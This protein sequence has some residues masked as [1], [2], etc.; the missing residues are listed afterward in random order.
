M[1]WV[2]T[3]AVSSV[4]PSTANS[5]LGMS[6]TPTTGAVVVGLNI[7]GLA[8]ISTLDDADTLAIYDGG[9]N[10]KIS[11]LQLEN[12]IGAAK[13]KRF[14]LNTTT[15]NVS[16]QASP[17]G[18]TIGWVVDV[19]TALG[20]STALDCAVEII[21]TS[22]GATVYAEIT[23]SGTDVTINFSGSVSQ[24]AYQALITRIY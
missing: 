6:V 23:R 4:S 11:L 10:K 5:L 20:V 24:G 7:N 12:H 19:G 1:P 18:G 16:Q 2:N 21:Q 17:P 14:I 22:N 15:T 9:T 3:Q 13:S 8:A